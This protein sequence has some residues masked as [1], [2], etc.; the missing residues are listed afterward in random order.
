MVNSKIR[1]LSFAFRICIFTA[2]LNFSC[3]V[4]SSFASAPPIYE[5]E[6]KIDI[7]THKIHAKE[8]VVFT[9]NSSGDL[10]E[11]YFHI[12]PHRKYRKK[13]IRFIYRFAGY[14]KINPFPEGFQSGDLKIELV[15]SEGKSIGYTIEGEDETILKVKFDS[16]I[17]PGES[18]GIDIDF[19]L[20]IPHA[21]GRFGWHKDIISL[22]RWYPILSVVN[23]E[24][25]H[26]YP[27]YLY[28]LPH[29]SDAAY[30]KV[31]LTLPCSQ[32]V[33]S[34]G[35]IKEEIRNSDGTKTLSIDTDFPLRDFSLG[36]SD[37]FFLYSFEYN[38]IKINSYYLAGSRKSAEIAASSAVGL[39]KFYSSRFGEYPY[40]EFNIVPS[41]LGYGGVQSSNQIFIDT[42]VYKL[43]G[44]L[45]RYFD[46]LIAHETGHQWFYNLIGSD[47]YK[48]MFLDEGINSYWV[49]QYLEDKY[50]KDAL[51]LE[52]PKFISWLIPNFSFRD[53]T[54]ARYLY[55]SKNGLGRPIIGELSSFQE[56]S[57][58][59]ALTYGKGAA[60]LDMLRGQIG[61]EAFK[62]IMRRYTKEYRFKNIS[63]AEF[64]SISNQEVGYNL[65]NFFEQW[66]KTNKT[67]DFSVKS[68]A[69]DKVVLEN[70]GTIAMPV[71]TKI[72]YHDGR[73]FVERWD[74]EGETKVIPLNGKIRKV[75][76]DPQEIITLDLDRTNNTW[77]K[78]FKIKAVPLYSPIYE[79]PVLLPRASYNLVFGP[80]IGGSSLGA[81]SFL[82][83]PYDNTLKISC[84]YDFGGEAVESKLG[85]EIAHVF[86][87]QTA[88]GFEL[89]DYQSRG[90]RD[91]LSGGKIYLRR[92]L[93]PASYGLLDLN[94]HITLYLIRNQKI[95]N[96]SNL[97][98]QEGVDNFYYRKK[99]E[100][101]FG[102]TGSLGRYGPYSDPAYGWKFMPTQEFAGHFL[103]GKQSF[104]RTTLEL[105]NYHLVIPKYQH[106]LAAKLK[107]GW[108]ESSD[109][110]LFQLGG[111]D[112]LR[113]YSRKTL[114]GAHM[115][116][117]GIEYRFPLKSEIKF[118]F[119]DNILCLDQIQAV[120]FCDLGKAWFT[121]FDG[122]PFKKDLGLGLRLHF[123][124]ASFLEKVVLRIDIAEAIN[125]SHEDP[126]LWIG[127]SHSF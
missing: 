58:I 46:F 41:Y 108:G 119:L 75:K 29:F 11:A 13:E 118:Y 48:E 90:K 107:L 66:L 37:K 57:S 69:A 109:K 59:F 102:I 126:R 18:K 111:P 44:F 95:E 96:S 106:K 12:Y 56:P 20:D 31:K 5:I 63:L 7:T 80:V 60:V 85:Y 112:G 97:N 100:A 25:W 115:L 21:Y 72:V 89:F 6:A 51:V 123:D 49:L 70:R 88:L 125:D 22:V 35:Y 62:G 24:G 19:Q 9:N 15:S 99:D 84:G 94:D 74:G 23:Q 10:P 121:E 124:I 105:D 42:R 53:S 67:A 93:W 27:F 110:K 101:I 113:G 68:V 127:V 50:G 77:P 79:I 61:D 91:D 76:I 71:D 4:S 36:V 83:K 103:G 116:L 78:D 43:P 30:Y 81:A 1:I 3:A 114:E 8:R 82:Q 16:P 39:M 73:G 34:S 86:N 92:E 38:N 104:W 2:L 52:L 120:A 54:I 40:R 64:V 17:R 122:R 98:G 26:N 47:E 28:H 32:K 14:F 55:L 65:D 45:S 87:K 117:G 33:A